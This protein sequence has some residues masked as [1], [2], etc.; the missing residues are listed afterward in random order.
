MPKFYVN[1]YLELDRVFLIEA[2]NAE[3]ACKAF[4]KWSDARKLSE[5]SV[6]DDWIHIDCYAID[7]VEPKHE[8]EE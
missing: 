3:E 5:Q 6:R 7:P 2:E 8:W 4:W 1:A